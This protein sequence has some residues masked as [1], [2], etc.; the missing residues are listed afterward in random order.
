MPSIAGISEDSDYTSDVSF[1]IHH[2]PNSSVHQWDSHL[3][4]NRH[5][6]PLDH[7]PQPYDRHSNQCDP[8][9]S[10]QQI[11]FPA[12]VSISTQEQRLQA[13]Y[14][15]EE[16]AYHQRYY[17]GESDAT[18]RGAN[19]SYSESDDR[20]YGTQFRSSSQMNDQFPRSSMS[21]YEPVMQ[22]HGYTTDTY[23]E[24]EQRRSSS[25][26]K[27]DSDTS[28]VSDAR[29]RRKRCKV[30]SYDGDYYQALGYDTDTHTDEYYPRASSS[31]ERYPNERHPH[32]DFYRE[33]SDWEQRNSDW[34]EEQE[35]LSY[36]SR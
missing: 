12:L 11:E 33:R 25:R 18:Q 31:Y 29:A 27:R 35:P 8:F 3:Y 30:F 5:A 7:T 14:E 6:R 15:D 9:K 22:E 34:T 23:D 32:D 1:P 24:Y 10:R 2:Q 16:D 20:E 4:P 19:E 13:S 17:E 28:N 26:Q 21:Y 36:N